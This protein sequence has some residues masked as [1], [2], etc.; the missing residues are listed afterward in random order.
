MDLVSVELSVGIRASVDCLGAVGGIIN[1]DDE[2][3][4]SH[5]CDMFAG[6]RG[7]TAQMKNSDYIKPP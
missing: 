5:K 4:T 1:V 3:R 7:E 6:F 2:M